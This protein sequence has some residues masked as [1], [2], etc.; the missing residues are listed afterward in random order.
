[1]STASDP[2]QILFCGSDD[3]SVA[4]LQALHAEHTRNSKLVKSIDVV[5]KPAKRTGR[6]LKVFREGSVAHDVW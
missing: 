3:F 1:M 4:S 2:L 6:G 5:C